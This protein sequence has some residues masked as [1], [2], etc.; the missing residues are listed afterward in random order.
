MYNPTENKKAPIIHSFIHYIPT[1]PPVDGTVKCNKLLRHI[2]V[3]IDFHIIHWLISQ[4]LPQSFESCTCP[5]WSKQ[6]SY[7]EVQSGLP[8]RKASK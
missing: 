6:I 5:L 4:L 1:L 3:N 7:L 8:R 2:P